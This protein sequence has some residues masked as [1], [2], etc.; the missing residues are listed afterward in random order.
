LSLYLRLPILKRHLIATTLNT[1][2]I[3]A[4]GGFNK[5][6][7]RPIPEVAQQWNRDNDDNYRYPRDI[8]KLKNPSRRYIGSVSDGSE[9]RRKEA[10]GI[11][12]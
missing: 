9:E 10:T 12:V 1:R 8:E 3:C 4:K 11:N 2:V 6:R 7:S 5:Q